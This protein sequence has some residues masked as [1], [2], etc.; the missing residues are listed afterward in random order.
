MIAGHD[1]E[2][3]GGWRRPYRVWIR[4]SPTH[5]WY[6]LGGMSLDRRWIP[7]SELIRMPYL[8]YYRGLG[9]RIPTP[10]I[11]RDGL[12]PD[13]LI[14]SE[15]FQGDDVEA[16]IDFLLIPSDVCAD[17]DR[18]NRYLREHGWNWPPD[19][20]E[21]ADTPAW[22]AR[23]ATNVHFWVS[24]SGLLVH[25]G[26]FPRLDAATKR[27]LGSPLWA[28]FLL[29]CS[30]PNAWKVFP[31]DTPD[32]WSEPL[33][34]LAEQR[35]WLADDALSTS[36]NLTAHFSTQR[37]QSSMKEIPHFKLKLERKPSGDIDGT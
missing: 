32:L 34:Y 29:V 4:S 2:W 27:W 22:T 30:G 36:A 10:W 23:T 31:H 25:F 11:D 19:G 33:E 12:D 9:G 37:R 24:R 5:W 7:T 35:P 16:A 3:C 17:F 6:K 15:L 26:H 28:A 20:P 8:G 18:T 1:T 13:G 21:P 14:G